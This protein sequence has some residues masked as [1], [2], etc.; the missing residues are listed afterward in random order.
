MKLTTPRTLTWLLSLILGVLGV[1]IALGQVTIR[2]F[3]SQYAIWL[4]AAGLAIML[5]TTV[6]LRRR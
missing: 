5:V 3:P 1:L 4:V 6:V 2:S